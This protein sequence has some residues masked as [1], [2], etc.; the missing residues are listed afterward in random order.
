MTALSLR[1]ATAALLVG[2]S[3]ALAPAPA[4]S[5][6]G[7]ASDGTGHDYAG[8]V[9]A[10]PLGG[11]NP[12]ASGVLISPTVFLTAAHFTRNFDRQGITRAR[13]SFDPV[14]GSASTWYTGSIH[15]N[16]AYDPTAVGDAFDAGDLAVI[17]FDRPVEGISPA[18]LPTIDLLDEVATRTSF[19][20]VGYGCQAFLPGTKS[21]GGRPGL[22]ADFSTSGTR[23]VAG[24]TFAQAGSGYLQIHMA[25]DAGI[26]RGDSG[27]PTLFA[28]SDTLA[29]IT[30][31]GSGYANGVL[32]DQRLDTKASRAF[33]AQFVTLP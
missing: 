6:V 25:H 27:G 16:P 4:R 19:D 29:G 9:D 33:L 13:V 22:D 12:V 3:V 1:V 26:C 20:V 18:Q 17:V 31:G 23:K 32:Y 14:V 11:E 8:V 21:A 7:G 24:G 5:I 15:T 30:S 28:S 10:T 2:A